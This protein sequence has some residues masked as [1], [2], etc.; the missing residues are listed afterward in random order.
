METNW[1]AKL[2]DSGTMQ[3]AL[4]VLLSMIVMV[5]SEQAGFGS[6]DR[7]F[8]EFGMNLIWFM[9]GRRAEASGRAAGTLSK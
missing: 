1:T 2:K 9:V 7:T 8:V 4:V 3:I 5:A 6:Y